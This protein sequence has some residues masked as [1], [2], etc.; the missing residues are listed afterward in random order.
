ML[1]YESKTKKQ[2]IDTLAE[3]SRRIEELEKINV[4]YREVEETLFR[5]AR[6]RTAILDAMFDFV[7]LAN[8]NHEIIWTNR[9]VNRQF[10]MNPDQLKGIPCYKLFNNKTEACSDCPALKSMNTGYPV[11]LKDR[12]FLGRNWAVRYYPLKDEQM[13]LGVYTDI[14]ERKVAEQALIEEQRLKNE[15]L[16]N[17]KESEEKYK[18]L[19]EDSR[20]A[21]IIFTKE[22]GFIDANQ[23]CLTLCGINKDDLHCINAWDFIVPSKAKTK[24]IKDVEEERSVVDYPTKVRKADGTP[25]DCLFTSSVKYDPSGKIVG[26]QGILRDITEKKKLEKRILRISERER[27]EIGQELHDGLGQLLTG[28]A[29]K[30]KSIEQQLER[31]S[32]PELRDVQRLTC[33]IN[34]AINTT[35]RL[36]KE[37]V[38]AS[39]QHG[40]M[41]TVLK[42][43]ACT[44]SHT[45]GIPC[46]VNSTCFEIDLDTIAANQL[47]RIA[48]EATLNAAK[49][50]EARHIS[51]SLVEEYDGIIL[52]IIDDGIGFSRDEK[53]FDGRGLHI[54]EY[55]AS[56]I[57]AALLVRQNTEG[58]TTVMCTIPRK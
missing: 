41:L 40:S 31:Q 15:L 32:V 3:A 13:I 29:L 14:T 20:D 42:E 11:T 2:R 35:R 17:L 52:S 26:Y 10:G 56:M 53:S 57:D 55:R 18:M 51:I 22:G 27:R 6:E 45:Y 46:T 12:A 1:H 8:S 28:I 39:L 47:Y 30:S 54:M 58:G 33:L 4:R 7:V 34:E 21:I 48:Q 5:T 23:A 24:F 49:H 50:S 38:P 36:T 9:A 16:A 25:I 44:I 19:F 37:L 43:M